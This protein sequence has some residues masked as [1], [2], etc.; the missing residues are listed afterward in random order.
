M[1][2]GQL[3][4]LEKAVRQLGHI[5]IF[6]RATRVLLLTGLLSGKEL[7]D[8]EQVGLLLIATS[9]AASRASLARGT[10]CEVGTPGRE[11]VDRNRSRN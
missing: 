1:E 8:D 5:L 10:V 2:N 9:R 3:R 11:R 6:S 4:G 7:S